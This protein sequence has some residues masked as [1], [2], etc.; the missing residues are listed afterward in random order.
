M[1]KNID[2]NILKKIIKNQEDIKNSI[3]NNH[4]IDS[5]MD[6]AN[7]YL[8]QIKEVSKTKLIDLK[9]AESILDR[10]EKIYT[11]T[12]ENP[13]KMKQKFILVA[14]YFVQVDDR[15]NDLNSPVGFDDDAELVNILIET[16]KLEI[17][18]IK[19]L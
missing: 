7:N 1:E 8:I 5:I 10:L 13:E 4:N 3:I 14:L 2:F 17:E 9:T 6:M 18:K 11:L 16:E 15:D 12:K 19:L